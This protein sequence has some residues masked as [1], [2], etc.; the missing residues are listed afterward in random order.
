MRVRRS[1]IVRRGALL[2]AAFVLVLP[3]A[4]LSAQSDAR[5]ELPNGADPNDWEAYFD[6][7]ISRL[8]T[9]RGGAEEPLAWA[10]RLNPGRAEPLHARWVAFWM[11]D[12][13]RF[14]KYLQGDEDV[15]HAPDVV[16]ADSLRAL[17]L[18]RNPF[19]H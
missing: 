5:P 19:V 9:H 2:V 16:A 3:A 18:Q 1:G 6:L 4:A 10:S 8:T 15:V 14:G 13:P 7:G 12:I 17:A 11:R